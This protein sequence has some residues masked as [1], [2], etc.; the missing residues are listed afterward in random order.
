MKRNKPGVPRSAEGILSD[1]KY[2]VE[3]AC[4]GVAQNVQHQQTKHGIKDGYT[5]FWIDRLIEHARILHKNHSARPPA[6][7]QAELLIWVHENKDNIYNPFLTL[8]GKSLVD[9]IRHLTIRFSQVLILLLIL[10]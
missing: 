7:I 1:V 6:D 9:I 2:Q 3:L 10:L 4:L 8:D 5:Q